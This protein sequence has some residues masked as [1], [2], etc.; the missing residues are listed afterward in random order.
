[1]LV[2]LVIACLV[3]AA[4]PLQLF[5]F[6]LR[7]VGFRIGD[8]VLR[9]QTSFAPTFGLARVGHGRQTALDVARAPK[10]V[11]VVRCRFADFYGFRNYVRF[12]S[13][14]L[15]VRLA[16]PFEKSGVRVSPHLR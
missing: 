16:A 14:V 5:F 8:D 7:L 6:V 4:M 1:M 15:S 3:S 10:A 12:E 11:V 9:W 13:E 2:R